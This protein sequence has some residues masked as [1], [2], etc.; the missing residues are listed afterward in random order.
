MPELRKQLLKGRLGAGS[1]QEELIP[2]AAVK[3]GTESY[4]APNEISIQI[5]S[6]GKGSRPDE[7][8]AEA[9][10]PI[11]R[12]ASSPVIL[13][14]NKFQPDPEK[15]S[16]SSVIAAATK[17]NVVKKKFDGVRLVVVRGYRN[18]ATNKLYSYNEG[19]RLIISDKNASRTEIKD[20]VR[21]TMKHRIID[22][23]KLKRR[24]AHPLRDT[25]ALQNMDELIVI[26]DPPER[27]TF[28][29]KWNWVKALNIGYPDH[30]PISEDVSEGF[31]QDLMQKSGSNLAVVVR[32]LNKSKPV[33]E[34]GNVELRRR[35]RGA[36][37]ERRNSL[38][39]HNNSGWQVLREKLQ[40][41]PFFVYPWSQS[42]AVDI[43]ILTWMVMFPLVIGLPVALMP[44][45]PSLDTPANEHTYLL[46]VGMPIL[47]AVTGLFINAWIG[48][49]FYI[50]MSILSYVIAAAVMPG[51]AMLLYSSL[52][53]LYFPFYNTPV[54]AML[55]GTAVVYILCYPHL[56]L[57]MKE[58]KVVRKDLTNSLVIMNFLILVFIVNRLLVT[59]FGQRDAASL[60]VLSIMYPVLVT[61]STEDCS[62]LA[63]AFNRKTVPVV[64]AFFTFV[65]SVFQMI[66]FLG[67][68]ARVNPLLIFFLINATDFTCL[69]LAGPLIAF[70]KKKNRKLMKKHVEDEDF[71]HSFDSFIKWLKDPLKLKPLLVKCYCE[72][73]A[74]LSFIVIS[75]V[76]RF[77]P[78]KDT[79]TYPFI[80]EI[81][82][83]IFWEAIYFTITE[84]FMF[85][86]LQ[87][88]IEYYLRKTNCQYMLYKEKR[89]MHNIRTII[90]CTNGFITVLLLLQQ[91][92]A[93]GAG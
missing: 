93:S 61:R 76:I 30:S 37:L 71:S 82:D 25:S 15:P 47:G 65:S 39:T 16:F 17:K 2:R 44:F 52:N 59:N 63:E 84:L 11:Q 90:G 40:Q 21:L 85:V 50:H 31:E 60:I 6:G 62:R 8:A 80:H 42:L 92:P 66:V 83:D 87:Y 29:M 78:T 55:L 23:M 89:N 53:M 86:F 13:Q 73:S 38:K 81:D 48:F 57:R 27:H 88:S 67:I 43:K 7:D 14:G 49:Y 79:V 41:R 28:C 75:M 12:A 77:G 34:E 74:K 19:R 72:I 22:I 64:E 9:L 70:L 5:E 18:E 51:V 26:S 56:P 36:E 3:R 35:S 1:S 46:Y 69:I 91:T 20:L 58:K 24:V 32:T 4:A 45:D 54:T 33:V 68:H 10:S